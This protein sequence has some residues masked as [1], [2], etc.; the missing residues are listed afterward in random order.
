MAEGSLIKVEEGADGVWTITINRPAALNSLTRPMMVDLAAAFARLGA[1]ERVRV[2]VLTGAGRAF[3]AGVD[4][5]AAQ[6]VFQGDVK[7]EAE[8]PV[9]QMERCKVPI[10]GAIN[11]HAV[12]AGFEIALAC[13][14]L[15][16]STAA[17]FVDTHCRFGIFPSW[18]LSQKLP[19]MIG[20]NCA[21][22]VSLAASP[23]TADMAARWGLVSA[24][25]PPEQLLP[26]AYGVATKIA[27]NHR[28]LVG[29]YKAVL[30]DGLSLPLGEG[31]KLE[32]ERAHEYY[33]TMKPEDF[34]AMQKFVAG[35]SKGASKGSGGQPSPARA[36]L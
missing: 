34:A 14:V 5:T 27:K 21:R 13:D 30:N 33:S 11:G 26:E 28:A 17:V 4:L 25:V 3:C 20:A 24:V 23:V 36:R 35:R 32:K 7:N 12:T 29:L 6:S 15:I 31:R 16:A 8:D 19:R 18:G 1:D 10:I 2:I 22:H 9:V